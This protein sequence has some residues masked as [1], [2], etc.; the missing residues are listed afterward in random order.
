MSISIINTP[1]R[2][3]T[4]GDASRWTA[5]DN[6]IDFEF[7]RRDVIPTSWTS[8]YGSLRITF[9]A[10][11]YP[12]LPG[13]YVYVNDILNKYT[14]AHLIMQDGPGYVVLNTTYTGNTTG[15]VNFI[16]TYPNYYLKLWVYHPGTLETI[17][18]LNFRSSPEGKIRANIADVVA[19][20]MNVNSLY[21]YT[22]VNKAEVEMDLDY[23]IKYREVYQDSPTLIQGALLKEGN[24]WMASKAVKQ[25]G[26]EFGQNM[27]NY[28]IY[29]EATAATKKAKFLGS[30]T[31][32]VY[33]DGF[34][35]SLSFLYT[36]KVV[37]V[38]YSRH[39]EQLDINQTLISGT[40]SDKFMD[41]ASQGHLNRLSLRQM[42]ALDDDARFLHVWIEETDE[43]LDDDYTGGG[44]TSGGGSESGIGDG[45]ASYWENYA[46]G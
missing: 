42:D 6:S 38:K 25:L 41:T 9:P 45:D 8:D 19:R 26:D 13:T 11:A 31:G 15:F 35:F 2:T 44:G 37:N 12:V 34:P 18:V 30:P 1:A 17:R 3:A 7:Q 39:V 5:S 24:E 10:T 23:K 40:D 28:M 14:G 22:L 21:N 33:F 36:E 27:R 20:E 16:G 29:P 46:G 32:D 43:G 4:T